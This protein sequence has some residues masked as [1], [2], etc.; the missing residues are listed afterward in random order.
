MPSTRGYN[1]LCSLS[2]MSN[3]TILINSNKKYIYLQYICVN[4]F[5]PCRMCMAENQFIYKMLASYFLTAL[6][7]FNV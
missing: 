1:E 2:M 3:Y 5:I 6:S 7:F 4:C